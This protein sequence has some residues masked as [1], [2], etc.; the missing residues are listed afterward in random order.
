MV[1]GLVAD[2]GA[3]VAQ[4]DQ[5]VE[6]EGEVVRLLD[7]VVADEEARGEDEELLHVGDH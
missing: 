3:V 5:G 2:V 7:L 1:E 6:V 4:A